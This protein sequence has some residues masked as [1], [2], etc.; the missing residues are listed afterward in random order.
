MLLGLCLPW[1]SFLLKGNFD[2]EPRIV[3]FDGEP[4]IGFRF[5]IVAL[6]ARIS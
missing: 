3:N 4:R 5:W 1:K 2:G 6:K